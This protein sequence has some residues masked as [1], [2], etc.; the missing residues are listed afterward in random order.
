MEKWQE[1]DF[2]IL[3]IELEKLSLEKLIILAKNTGIVF[4]GDSKMENVTKE[5]I[6][7]V[8]DETDPT[9]LKRV[10]HELK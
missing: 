8:L 5:D 10:L 2:E 1:E 9:E 3:K 4:T 6:I 7:L